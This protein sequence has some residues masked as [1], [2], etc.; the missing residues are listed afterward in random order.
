M[1]RTKFVISLILLL[2]LG[3]VESWGQNVTVIL[4][5]QAVLD[6][7]VLEEGDPRNPDLKI[8][9]TTTGEVYTQ[10][11]LTVV[12]DAGST[13]KNKTWK[14]PYTLELLSRDDYSFKGWATSATSTSLKMDNPYSISANS[15]F[16]NLTA[17]RSYYVFLHSEDA[18]E[19]TGID[20]VAFTGV[21]GNSYVSGSS[22]SDWKVLL[23]FEEKLTYDSTTPYSGANQDAK[24]WIS[25]KNKDT[26]D[27]AAFSQVYTTS[28]G[29]A[30]MTFPYSIP[31]GKYNVHLPYGLFTTVE[32]HPTAPCD[33]EIDVIG[34]DAPFEL[35]GTTPSDNGTWNAT[36][37]DDEGN[38]TMNSFSI[39]C[40]F[41][42]ILN[43]VNI[44]GKDLSIHHQ[45]TGKIISCKSASINFTD[46]SIANLSYGIIPNGNYTVTIPDGVFFDADGN[47]NE[48]ISLNFTVVGSVDTWTLP[49]FEKVIKTSG[50]EL[51]TGDAVKI[52][53]TYSSSTYGPAVSVMPYA[54]KITASVMRSQQG[55]TDIDEIGYVEIPDVSYS[56]SDGT[57]EIIIPTV[58]FVG[59]SP[60]SSG[61]A[62]NITI[63]DEESIYVNIPQG[64][65]INKPVEEATNSLETLYKSGACINGTTNFSFN[66][67]RVKN[68]D[69]NAD[70][71]VDSADVNTLVDIVLG[72][73]SPTSAS[74]VNN[75]GKVDVRD[76]TELL[77]ILLG[78]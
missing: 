48:S 45:E 22:S 60:F 62:I 66:A 75:D 64:F 37:T 38:T 8:T 74:D 57:I 7:V 72:K 43:R 67:K 24:N 78:K 19:P 29:N 14:F 13:D 53:V 55:Q 28:E 71:K 73:S 10:C 52:S 41:S 25:I 76:V 49:V 51:Y 9:N 4:K 46:K 26:N 42:K 44:A 11:P 70:G 31:A 36:S 58:D 63:G 17:T 50:S 56:F 2:M 16:G 34:N 3:A 68:G 23:S 35:K 54:G 15:S 33:F 61:G 69:V 27:N 20:G 40:A 32:G 6:G 39:N 30:M 65:V 12:N 77:N 18:V 47:S 5:V 1:K 21:S 59:N